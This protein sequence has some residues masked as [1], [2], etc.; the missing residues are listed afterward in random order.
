MLPTI[1]KECSIFLKESNGYPLLKNLPTNNDG[2]RKVKVRKK[3]NVSDNLTNVFNETFKDYNDLL[4]R[5]I[6][7][8]TI[9]SFDPSEDLEYEPFYIF[10]INGYKFLYAEGVVNTTESY[11]NTLDKLLETY[12]E[13]GIKTFQELL[14]YQYSFTKL[15]DALN[16]Y[17]EIII[18]D[19]PYYY[20]IR[21]SLIEDYQKFVG[22]NVT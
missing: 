10:P 13:N 11:K 17:S 7:A 9:I 8:Y 18:Y 6:F 14:K 21:Y 19:I 1:E 4:Q 5:A 20:A 12:G 2:F 22:Y 16:S 3:K 15:G